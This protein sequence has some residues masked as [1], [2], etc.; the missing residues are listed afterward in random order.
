MSQLNKASFEAANNDASTGRYKTGQVDGIGSDDH[1]AMIVDLKDSVLFIED[2][3]LDEDDMASDSA[4]QVPSQQSV[5]AYVDGLVVGLWDDRGNYDASVDDTFPATGGSG[6]SGAILKGDIWTVSVAGTIDGEVVNIG[7]TVRAIADSPAQDGSNWAIGENNIGYTPE[8]STNKV[9][10]F[11]TVNNTLYPT[12]Q[13][14]AN[15]A[16]QH[17]MTSVGDLVRGG[18]AGAPTRIAAG[19]NGYVLT[20][21][22][23][24]PA[25]ASSASGFSDPMTTRGDIIFRN[26]SNVTASLAAGTAGYVL[27]SDGTD[28]A[29][30][31]ATGGGWATTGTTTLTG[32]TSIALGS[33]SLNFKK[34]AGL[35]GTPPQY[36]QIA[37]FTRDGG[38]SSGIG[39][40]YGTRGFSDPGTEAVGIIRGLGDAN[41]MFIGTTTK[42]FAIYINSNGGIVLGSS[43]GSIVNDTNAEISFALPFSP[44]KSTVINGEDTITGGAAGDLVLK[45][46]NI[47][48]KKIGL[49]TG[50]TTP[51]ARLYASDSGIEIVNGT[52]L[53]GSTTFTSGSI[54]AEISSTTK[55]LLLSRVTSNSNITTKVAGMLWY[56]STSHKYFGYENT[57]EI[58]FVTASSGGSIYKLT[59]FASTNT[60][61][62]MMAVR[63][64]SNGTPAA[65]IGA[66]LDISVDSAAGN[67]KTGQ[68][69]HI[70]SNAA[71]TTTTAS[72]FK[73]RGYIAGAQ[74]DMFTFLRLAALTAADGSGVNSGDGTT[75]T[76]IDNMR[77]RINQLEARLQSFG[78]IP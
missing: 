7:D 30:A 19:T 62:S 33:Y 13:A 54:I 17:V 3:L 26:S 73:L 43:S 47:A 71:D 2:H 31:A 55:A 51:L 25:W 38:S 45:S 41:R 27:T 61:E 78:L 42:P 58:E 59:S 15:Y 39:I 67:P 65:G 77:T 24:V 5:K 40:G 76:V 20:M 16:M 50:L 52:L 56:N 34:D 11:S 75:D 4:T 69:V 22:A 35:A 12:V 64:S 21:V 66:S 72:T 10:D 63:R 46:R 1:R 9:T 18:T 6:A 48:G 74:V 36:Y 8:N 60:V 49:F 68:L 32:A 57:S 37:S 29:W 70:L 44:G 28:I 14:V 23:G 53:V